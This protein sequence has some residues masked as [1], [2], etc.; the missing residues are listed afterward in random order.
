MK[1]IIII[2]FLFSSSIFC[3]NAQPNLLLAQADSLYDV[4]QYNDALALRSKYIQTTGLSG[5]NYS[6]QTAKL[7]LTRF[8]IHQKNTGIADTA[9]L[10][11]ILQTLQGKTNNSYAAAIYAEVIIAWANSLYNQDN[12]NAAIEFLN[13]LIANKQV[14]NFCSHFTKVNIYYTYA[15]I[16]GSNS[17][18]YNNAL[19]YYNKAI[20]VA[21]ANGLENKNII[22]LL[23]NDFGLLYD[24]LG[25]RDKT[26]AYYTKAVSIWWKYHKQTQINNTIA[27]FGNLIT[28]LSDY[29]KTK[30]ATAYLDTLLQYFNWVKAA[31]QKKQ[32]HYRTHKDNLKSEFF[33]LLTAVRCYAAAKKENLMLQKLKELEQILL[34]ANTQIKQE[35]LPHLIEAYT[36]VALFYREQKNFDAAILYFGKAAK[37][38]INDFYK[39]KAAANMAVTYNYQNKAKEALPYVNTALIFFT[40]SNNTST[41]YYGLLATKAE[42]L[43]KHN[44]YKEATKLLDTLYS[45]LLKTTITHQQL[46]N[47]PFTKFSAFV[48]HTQIIVFI[49][50]ANVYFGLYNANKQQQYLQSAHHFYNLAA[51][52]FKAYYSREFYNNTLYDLHKQITNGLL[53]TGL[54]LN[55][56]NH[57]AILNVVENNTSQ[58]LWKKFISRFSQNIHVPDSLLSQRNS[59]VAQISVEEM[60]SE[61]NKNLTELKK[62]LKKIDE[63]IEQ[64]SKSFVGFASQEF[65]INNLQKKLDNTT[66]VVRYFSTDSSVFAFTITN[67]E[68]KLFNIGA[69]NTIDSLISQL[70][71]QI[72]TINHQYKT[73][74]HFLYN[75]LIQKLVLKNTQKLI[76]IPDA[77][78][79]FLPFELL[80]NTHTQETLLATTNISYSYSL[81][82]WLMQ[83]QTTTAKNGTVT[84]API[85]TGN[86]NSLVNRNGLANLANAQTEAQTIAAINKGTYFGKEQATT[87]NF[88]NSLGK[89][90]MYHLA[91]HAL[92]NEEQPENSGLIFSNNEM[93]YFKQLYEIN[94]PSSLVVLSACNTGIGAMETG[95]GLMSL[96]RA[97][98]Y[99]GVQASVYSLWQVPDEETSAIMI[100]FYKNLANKQTKDEALANAKK[101]FLQNNP[102]KQHPFY[103]AGFVVNGNTEPIK[104]KGNIFWFLFVLPF[105]IFWFLKSKKKA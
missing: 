16:Y 74:T 20:T 9:A 62:Q 53:Q 54:L 49:K 28:D 89:Y 34:N 12:T 96:S 67:K 91:M 47:I 76:I 14:F 56:T 25:Q 78:L 6:I 95:E 65:L 102:L 10:K 71:S 104:K 43:H 31:T 77:S 21:N 29:G 50:T 63:A 42:L 69:T 88:F 101:T 48:N 23:Y 66:T 57:A 73:T 7:E 94:F 33:V 1:G 79:H 105:V 58:H 30:D 3:L 75:I 83:Q 8:Y 19:E 80:Y 35:Y 98:T 13:N 84:F 45:H 36:N 86:N 70:K 82:L 55:N 46:A 24:K 39:M 60:K 87:K 5:N 85:Y 99:S 38:P 41:S 92:V 22:A 51:N 64:Y 26:I 100:E 37:Y 40:N 90:N 59:L 11:K 52:M 72:L 68:I 2:F 103:W 97:L 17:N 32:L 27:G 61:Q 81:P 18:T 44:N 15:T 4:E 93:L